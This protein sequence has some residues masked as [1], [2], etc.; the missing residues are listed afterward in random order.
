[1]SETDL[2][3]R[4]NWL[5]A[6]RQAIGKR[7]LQDPEWCHPK[8]G[9]WWLW[10]ACIWFGQ[11]FAVSATRKAKVPTISGSTCRGVVGNSDAGQMLSALSTRLAR[12]AVLSGDWQRCLSPAVSGVEKSNCI[13]VFLDPP[14]SAAADCETVV[15]SE[16]SGMV[17]AEVQSW[18]L[19]HGAEVNL[20][21]ALCGYE[22]EYTMP[23]NWATFAW[24]GHGAFGRGRGHGKGMENR[25]R[26]RI[27]FSPHCLQSS[28]AWYS[29]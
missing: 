9:G 6:H 5:A 18:A 28:K 15:Y 2:V 1:M 21:I 12:V 10:G 16:N 27:W 7:L 17:S 8:A 3:A 20:R 22:G 26:E 24:E 14:Y 11:G 19:E 4:S 23:D 13:G 25:H 29:P